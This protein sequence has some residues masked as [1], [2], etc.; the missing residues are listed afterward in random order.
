MTWVLCVLLAINLLLSG[1]ALAAGPYPI[2]LPS[3]SVGVDPQAVTVIGQTQ[4]YEIKKGDTLLDIA[5]DYGLGYQELGQL[6]RH[7]DPFILP[8]GER[9]TIPTSWIVPDCQHHQIV[10][11]TGEMRLYKFADN[12]RTVY[13]FPIGMGVLDYKTPTGTFKVTEKK[14]K[15]PWYVPKSLQAKYGMAVMPPGPDNPLGDYKLTLSWGDYGIHGTS[16]PWGVGR[17]VSHGCTRMYPEHIKKL[18]AMVKVG[19]TVE[20]IYEPVKIGFRQGRVYLEVNQDFYH[21]IPDLLTY[22][23]NRL[24]NRGLITEVDY[25]RVIKVVEEKLGI[26]EE[27]TKKAE[28]VAASS[29]THTLGTIG[30]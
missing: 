15:P 4:E 24:E 21:K 1:T 13:T 22:T 14:V 25:S 5:R 18:F 10:V 16:M 2:H 11:N 6:Y 12:G 20:Y 28:G 9:L 29:L 8:V 27:V 26:P 3:S 23:L 30:E 19:T 7:W 17:L